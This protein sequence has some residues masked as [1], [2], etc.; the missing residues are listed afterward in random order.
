MAGTIGVATDSRVGRPGLVAKPYLNLRIPT[1]CN[2]T[3]KGQIL[4]FFWPWPEIKVML[5][6]IRILW[7]RFSLWYQFHRDILPRSWVIAKTVSQKLKFGDLWCF[8]YWP[9]LK[10][11]SYR[12]MFYSWA[13]EWYESWSSSSRSR[14]TPWLHRPC[15]VYYFRFTWV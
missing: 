11:I 2:R 8:H 6:I 4:T 10:I 3:L 15:F 14:V 13:F 12:E 7:S 1:T 9:D 5:C